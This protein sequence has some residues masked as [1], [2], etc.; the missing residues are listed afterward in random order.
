MSNGRVK[1]IGLWVLKG[2]AAI[3]FLGAASGKL[4][5]DPM[6]VA[7]FE[8]IGMGQGF[9]YLTGI[10]EVVGAI[11]LLIPSYAFYA[12]SLLAAVMVGAIVT[13]VAIIGGSFLPAL[14]FLILV[15]TIAWLS[16]AERT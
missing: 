6:M 16:R 3:A 5:G 10:L 1:T 4:T 2:L 12:A 9:R 13:H 11:G 7:T 8:K 15:G 14:I